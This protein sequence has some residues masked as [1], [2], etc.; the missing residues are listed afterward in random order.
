MKRVTKILFLFAITT[1][2]ILNAQS[3]NKLESAQKFYESEQW[4]EA[5]TAFSAIIDENKYNG[6]YYYY[7]AHSFYKLK[8][9]DNAIHN[10]N[11]SLSLGYNYGNSIKNIAKSYAEK[12]DIKNTQIWVNK[13]LQTPKSLTIA[14]VVSDSSFKNFIKT[15]SFKSIYPQDPT[16]SRKKKWET[17]IKFLKQRFEAKHFDVFNN[18]KEEE[19]NSDFNLLLETIDQKT[20][21]EVLVNLMK[22]ITKI[23]DGHTFIRPPISGEFK[24]HFYPFKL[25]MF[26]KGLFVTQTSNLYKEVLGL[27]LTHINTCPIKEVLERISKVISVDNKI[28]FLERLD[29]NIMFSEV[30]QTLNITDNP[31]DATFT[32][33]KEDGSNIAID[34]T[35]DVFNPNAITE[36]IEIEKTK[37][38]LY[39]KNENEF[40][41]SQELKDLN[42]MYIKINLNLSTPQ[43]SIRQ[44]YGSVFDSITKQNIKHL[45]I[46]LRQC[47]GGNSYNNNTLIKEIIANK[48]LDKENGL[49]TIIGRR[50]FSAAM[51]LTT[52]LETWTNTKFIGEPTGSKPNFIGET[53]F[54]TLPNTGLQVSISDANWQ[55]S[56]S[57][58]ERNW[59]APDIYEENSFKDYRNGIDNILNTI[60]TILL[61]KTQI[62]R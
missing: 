6:Q 5:V 17:D 19:W 36:K 23:G 59:I 18:V 61:E 48:T 37:T 45:I 24:L 39:L 35:A 22:I 46:D 47:P 11:L 33:Q 16:F 62:K 55:K 58:D 49:F 12:D 60:E 54:V 31:K 15:K 50:T 20:N 27:R 34:V 38:P 52:D 40:F 28:G 13:G 51:N 57:W 43:K 7:L 44:F 25:Y 8:N 56:V 53:S 29:F 30:L 4:L 41:W 26:K 10:Y 1:N 2:L 9:Y 32:F 42:A 21:A 14:N 3:I